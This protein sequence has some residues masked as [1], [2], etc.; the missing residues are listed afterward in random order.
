MCRFAKRVGGGGFCD[1]CAIV[2]GKREKS[3]KINIG[4]N[5]NGT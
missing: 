3:D 1:L 5:R 2:T 4:V